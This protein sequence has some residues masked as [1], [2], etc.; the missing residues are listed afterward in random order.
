MQYSL[1]I[2]PAK[3]IWATWVMGDFPGRYY[4]RSVK[5]KII[6]IYLLIRINDKRIKLSIIYTI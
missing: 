5:L 1:V 3:T 2:E 6:L 4:V